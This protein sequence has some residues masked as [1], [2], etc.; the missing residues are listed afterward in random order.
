VR[1]PASV[2]VRIEKAQHAFGL[3]ERLNQSIQQQPVEAPIAKLDAILVMLVKGVHGTSSVVRYLEAYSRERL[4]AAQPS[5]EL[6]TA[7]MPS[8]KR[9]SRAKPLAS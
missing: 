5:R 2:A 6:L 3:L 4:I 8:P 1:H 7:V 9:I